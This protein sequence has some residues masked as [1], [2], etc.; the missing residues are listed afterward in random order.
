ML[1]QKCVCVCKS[2]AIISRNCER[3]QQVHRFFWLVHCAKMGNKIT[4]LEPMPSVPLLS[5]A[6]A[7]V[8]AKQKLRHRAGLFYTFM[9]ESP[10]TQHCAWYATF[11]TPHFSPVETLLLF[12]HT[13]PTLFLQP[14]FSL[15]Q[16]PPPLFFPTTR[17]FLQTPC[18]FLQ[19]PPSAAGL[20]IQR[21]Q[22]SACMNSI[23]GRREQPK[24]S[25]HAN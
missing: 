17:P 5:V 10:T 19:S 14:L 3:F 13:N 18:I 16:T 24:C 23:S 7:A 1:A 20:H 8:L 15:L 11:S 12:L 6:S 25:K 9:W 4:C 2:P 22:L 21:V